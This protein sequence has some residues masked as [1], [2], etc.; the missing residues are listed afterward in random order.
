[1]KYSETVEVAHVVTSLLSIMPPAA[2][3]GHPHITAVSLIMLRPLDRLPCALGLRVVDVPARQ[4]SLRYV[5]LSR[6]TV[7]VVGVIQTRQG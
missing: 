3:L 7:A 5:P 4:V 1:M 2:L 6:G